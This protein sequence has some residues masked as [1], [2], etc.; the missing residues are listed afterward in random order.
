MK[1]LA[2]ARSTYVS[3]NISAAPIVG[4]PKTNPHF[5][6]TVAKF[7]RSRVKRNTAPAENPEEAPRQQQANP[8]GR[9]R[10]TLNTWLCCPPVDILRIMI[11]FEN[12]GPLW[13]QPAL[14]PLYGRIRREENGA[15]RPLR[16]GLLADGGER[17][18]CA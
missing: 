15:V 2:S 5:A 6:R 1:T 7:Y 4:Q 17:T 9:H 13:Q 10:A 18:G 3:Y 14:R 12:K 11:R 16:K 8:E